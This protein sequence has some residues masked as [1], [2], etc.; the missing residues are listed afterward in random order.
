[1]TD[2]SLLPAAVEAQGMSFDEMVAQVL[3]LA[4]LGG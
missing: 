4:D 3:D 2:T 1:M